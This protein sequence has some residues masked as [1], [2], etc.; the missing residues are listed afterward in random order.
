MWTIPTPPWTLMPHIVPVSQSLAFFPLVCE[1]YSYWVSKIRGRLWM[2]E[3]RVGRD[4]AWLLV[5]GDEVYC[6]RGAST[7]YTQGT[8]SP[9][10][11]RN[12]PLSPHTS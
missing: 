11:C 3:V 12:N 9:I 8:H 7:I 4:T 10:L 5:E 2:G 6:Y 1:N